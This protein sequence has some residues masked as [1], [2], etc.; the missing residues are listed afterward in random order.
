MKIAGK[1]KSRRELYQFLKE[2]TELN[3]SCEEKTKA[4]ILITELE[5]YNGLVNEDYIR[6]MDWMIDKVYEIRR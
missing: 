5:K 6:L 4:L 1:V 2:Y 3:C